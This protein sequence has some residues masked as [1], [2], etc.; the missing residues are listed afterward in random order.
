MIVV[1]H[2]GIKSGLL[3]AQKKPVRGNRVCSLAQG[4]S[5]LLDAGTEKAGWGG[6]FSWLQDQNTNFSLGW[7]CW[8]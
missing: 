4:E 1:S 6:L 7:F 2:N 5:D 8:M 3:P